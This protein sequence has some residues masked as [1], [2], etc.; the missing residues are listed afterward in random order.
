MKAPLSIFL[1]LSLG[2][3]TAWC[4]LL[5]QAQQSEDEREAYEARQLPIAA[6]AA[7]ALDRS[8]LV[9][10]HRGLSGNALKG[11]I[12]EAVATM[13]AVRRRLVGG[14]SFLQITKLGPGSANQAGLDALLL[15][16]DPSGRPVGATVLEAKFGRGRL[17]PGQLTDAWVRPRAS[18]LADDLA[19]AARA[20]KAGAVRRRPIPMGATRTEILLNY[21]GK[22]IRL[23]QP[24]GSKDWFIAGARDVPVEEVAEI[25]TRNA[26]YLRDTSVSF[27]KILVEVFMSGEDRISL[28]LKEVFDWGPGGMRTVSLGRIALQPSAVGARIRGRIAELLQ[29]R[30][31]LPI[32][33]ARV[34]ADSLL[35]SVGLKELL[36]SRWSWRLAART[37]SFAVLPVVMDVGVPLYEAVAGHIDWT[38]FAAYAATATATAAVAL[39]GSVLTQRLILET[40]VGRR[41]VEHVAARIG[42]QSAM[43]LSKFAVGGVLAVVAYSYIGALLGIH[44]IEEAHLLAA[45]S[46]AG[47]L[48]GSLAA[49]LLYNLAL[50]YGVASTGTAIAALS[51]AAAHSAALAWLGGGA[52]AAGGFGVFGGALILTGVGALAALATQF[53]VHFA[54]NTYVR[55][56]DAQRWAAFVKSLSEDGNRGMAVLRM[57]SERAGTR[58]ERTAPTPPVSRQ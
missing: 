33:E 41:M 22:N 52:V 24:K 18:A 34:Y 14:N 47:I 40:Q 44:T 46:T 45:T 16:Q 29:H 38:V 32:K 36:S 31:G 13:P 57:L 5:A 8:E 19:D 30:Y 58:V 48:V 10:L 7:V 25:L 9:I 54:W 42:Q 6:A 3:A 55:T 37:L 56:W 26:R 21:K 17:R 23:V 35:R 49:T 43:W 53:A 51:G 1:R 2:L 12:G 27:R 11:E 15:Q 20:L 4:P 50:S 28:H 39:A